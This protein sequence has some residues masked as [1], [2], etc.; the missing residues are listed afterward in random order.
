VANHNIFFRHEFTNYIKIYADKNSL[1]CQ[2]EASQNVF[3]RHEFTN[4]FKIYAD[5][6]SLIVN[7]RLIIT[8]ILG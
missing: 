5:R 6:I 3:F 7:S 4:Y 2:F 8:R 1:N